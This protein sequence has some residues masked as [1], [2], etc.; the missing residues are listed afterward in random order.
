MGRTKYCI[1]EN[2]KDL[3]GACSLHGKIVRFALSVS[4]NHGVVEVGR[5]TNL[6]LSETLA[7]KSM[8]NK[9]GLPRVIPADIKRAVR[10]AWRVRVRP[11][12]RCHR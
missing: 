12:W 9:Y 8:K 5:A 11:L 1:Y 4:G 7:K 3:A 10:Q 2:R 6:E